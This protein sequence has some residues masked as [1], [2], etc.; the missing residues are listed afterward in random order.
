MVQVVLDASVLAKLFLEE[1]GSDAAA[2]LKDS[3]VEGKIEI[4]SPSLAKYELMNVL[5]YKGFTKEEIKEALEAIRAYGFYMTEFDDALF[6]RTAEL[7]VD[8]NISVYD[9][10]YI[11]L[12][13][14]TGALLYTSDKKL[15]LK[16]KKLKFVKHLGES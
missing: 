15:L 6:D 14:D 5:R 7:S 12:A 10:S 11:A 1:D 9:A 8:H 13:E 3:H 4:V 16:V 2:G